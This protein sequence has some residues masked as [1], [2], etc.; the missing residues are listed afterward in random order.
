MTMR[1]VRYHEFGGPEKL[2]IEQ[3]PRPEPDGEN[4]LIQITLAGVSPLDDKVRGGVLPPTMRKPLPLVPGA[5]A[6][7]RVADPGA[8]GHAPGTRVLL[9]GW[10]Y[11]TKLDGTWR[12]SPPYRLA[13]SS[14]FPT[15]SATTTPRAW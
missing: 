10:G 7:G 1:A 11:G 2:Q 6:V 13:T 9:C 8:S 4:V 14:P 3:I 12:N 15:A 5:S